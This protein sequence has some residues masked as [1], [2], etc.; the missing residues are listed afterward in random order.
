MNDMSEKPEG[1]EVEVWEATRLPW[2]PVIESRFGGMNI[3]RNEWKILCEA[4]FPAAKEVDSIVMALA[5]CKNRNLDVMKRVVHIVPMWSPDKKKLVDTIWPGIAELRT[6]AMRT[7]EYAGNDRIVFGPMLEKE[8]TGDI[9]EWNNGNKST[10]SKTIKVRFP[11]WAEMTVYRIVKGNKEAFCPP[12][13]YW[14]ETYGMQGKTELPNSMW[15]RR[16]RGQFAKCCEAAALRFAF[17]E[18]LGNQYA[19]EEMEGQQFYGAEN[20]KVIPQS[21]TP[22]APPPTEAAKPPEEEETEIVEPEPTPEE[23]AEELAE[24]GHPEEA[25]QIL[26]EGEQA[27][28]RQQSTTWQEMFVELSEKIM[29]FADAAEMHDWLDIV[30]PKF[31]WVTEQDKKSG[32]ELDAMVVD[33]MNLLKDDEDF[34]RE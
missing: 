9:V 29:S 24:Q 3:T 27:P 25:E 5:Y 30:G 4:I 28:E 23:K 21:D 16:A 26:A 31:D 11:E 19:A 22:S 8:F 17:P 7:T 20:A 13:I 1:K 10:V 18:E 12:P 2:H 6:T 15:Q 14:E 34:R 33:K 32:E